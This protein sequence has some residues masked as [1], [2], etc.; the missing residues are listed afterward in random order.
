[1]G[2]FLA[3]ICLVALIIF[4]ILVTAMALNYDNPVNK[5]ND[6]QVNISITNKNKD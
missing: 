6:T 5:Q 3:V 2:L 1:M 4:I